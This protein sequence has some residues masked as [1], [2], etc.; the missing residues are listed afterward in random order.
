MRHVY[1]KEKEF[2]EKKHRYPSIGYHSPDKPEEIETFFYFLLTIEDN[3][4]KSIHL[5]VLDMNV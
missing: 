5:L 3:L 1:K 4:N 2:L